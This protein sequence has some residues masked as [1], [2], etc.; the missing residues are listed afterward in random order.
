MKILIADDHEL[1]RK[2]LRAVL[3]ERPGWKVCGE[4]VNGRHAVELAKQLRPDVIVLDITMPELN[5]PEAT[6]QIR[7]A[8][9][10]AEVLILTMHESDQLVSEV[11][12]AG[13][14][15]YILKADT[16]RLL[17]TA[18][19]SLSQHKPFFTGKVLEVLVEGNRKPGDAAKRA[20]K[21][22][23]RL[24]A[25]EREVL[26]LVAEGKF[27]KEVADA[28][29]IAVKTVEAHRFNIMH[30]LDLHSVTELVHY[31]IRNQMVAA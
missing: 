18:I 25:R 6:R 9:P 4:A 20:D 16:S 15:G 10:D 28:L 2:G 31:A 22:L 21:F 11:L 19:E 5:G 24:T 12:A 27:N 14:R 30:K 8:L 29:G 23:A 1:V 17:V 13:A 7:K 26:Q 3:E